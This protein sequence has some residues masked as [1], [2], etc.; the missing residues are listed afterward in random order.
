MSPRLVDPGELRH[1]LTFQAP[2]SERRP[3][4]SRDE[5]WADAFTVWGEVEPISGYERIQ[6]MQTTAGLTHRI[7]IRYRAGVL[8]T[9][10]ILH[11]GRTFAVVAPP[12]DEGEAGAFLVILA[13]EI[14]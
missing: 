8:P 12:I 3:S 11:R 2:T 6:A 9:M 5:S 10:R 7:R 1:R 13:R 4:G 14:V